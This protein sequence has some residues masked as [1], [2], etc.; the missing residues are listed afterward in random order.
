MI[1][2]PPAGAAPLLQL[3]TRCPP[4]NAQSSRIGL[5]VRGF[6]TCSSQPGSAAADAGVR[7]QGNFAR[8]LHGGGDVP[9]VLGA[10]AGDPPSTD[11][12]TIGDERRSRVVS[13]L[14]I[15]ALSLQKAQTFFFGIRSG[16]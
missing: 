1:A 15:G 2:V 7:K 5:H 4:A 13:L 3:V 6:D 11:F 14:S 12:A 10:V 9:L 16:A 8:V